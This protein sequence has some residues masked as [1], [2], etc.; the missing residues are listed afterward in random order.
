MAETQET[1]KK[2]T[3]RSSVCRLCGSSYES[4]R[5]CRILNKTENMCAK[6]KETC[7]INVTEDD[8]LSK[9]GRI[10]NKRDF[11]KPVGRTATTSNPFSMCSKHLIW[12][13]FKQNEGK[14]PTFN[15]LWSR[16]S[17]WIFSKRFDVSAILEKYLA[18]EIIALIYLKP[19]FVVPFAAFSKKALGTRLIEHIQE[20]FR[21]RI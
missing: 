2:I 18:Y 15:A 7:K 9:F 1:P 17:T 11:P 8:N 12:S 20:C 3:A 5:M 4:H 19:R 21:L 16:C 14:L 10:W 6:I 13:G